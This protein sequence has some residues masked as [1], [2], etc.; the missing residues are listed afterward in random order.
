MIQVEEHDGEL[1]FMALRQCQTL[2]QT[3]VKQGAVGQTG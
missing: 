1:L 2:I 3:V